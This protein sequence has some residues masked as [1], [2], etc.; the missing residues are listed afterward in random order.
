MKVA[1][2]IL[3]LKSKHRDRGIGFYTSNLIE[4]LKR[5]SDLEIQE[6]ISPSEIKKADIVHYPW[7]DFSFHTL[8]IKK[9]YPTIVTIHDV[10][11]LIFRNQYPV[12]FQGKFNFI[13]QKLALKGCRRIITDSK[14]SKIDLSKYLKIDQKKIDVVYLAAN[15][16]FK[17]QS[18]TKL[19]YVKRKYKLPDKFLLYVGD[20]NWV[21]NLPFLI[22]G[23]NNLIQDPDF[24]DIKLVMVGGVFLKKVENINHPE[25]E[26]LKKVNN[27]IR[28]KNLDIFTVRP[29]D[30]G[31]EDLVS[32]YN[33]ATIYVQPSLYEGFGLPIIEALSCSTPV[34]SSNKGSLMEIGG[35]AAVY[36]DPT[37]TNQFVSILKEVLQNKSLQDK[38]SKLGLKQAARFSW[39]KVAADTKLV[40]FKAIKSE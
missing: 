40:Y 14:T 27:L 23:F 37:N 16:N 36:F 5:D 15:N 12:G 3:P 10:I 8:P 38:L 32:F 22:E 21:K 26:S 4:N 18:G 39:E 7:F 1:I 20:A 17:I 19:L 6:F 34:V 35:D 24:K 29:G 28:D 2:N 31:L 33:L 30:I 25:L 11:P 13:L 9:I